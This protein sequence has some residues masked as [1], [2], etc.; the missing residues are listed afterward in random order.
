MALVVIDMP[1]IVATRVDS[2]LVYLIGF[3]LAKR[4]LVARSDCNRVY[5]CSCGLL[6][7]KNLVAL[8]M[9]GFVHK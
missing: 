2:D 6:L 5:D 7:R 9:V 1:I 3:F 4:S 8:I